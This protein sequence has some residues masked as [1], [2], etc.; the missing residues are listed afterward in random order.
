MKK[1]LTKKDLE[2]DFTYNLLA[3]GAIL[4]IIT[5][6]FFLF[7]A[8]E[9][10]N[11]KLEINSMPHKYCHNETSFFKY[12]NMSNDSEYKQIRLNAMK[13]ILSSGNL[14]YLCDSTSNICLEIIDKEVCEIK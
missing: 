9:I 3:V 10:N 11:I 2:E 6:I 5:F 4:G 14:R 7:Y 8:S 1:Y 13:S 12:Y